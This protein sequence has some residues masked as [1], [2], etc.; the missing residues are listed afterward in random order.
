MIGRPED[1]RRETRIITA[2]GVL[3]RKHCEHCKQSNAIRDCRFPGRDLSSQTVLPNVLVTLERCLAGIF[4]AGIG[5]CQ[6]WLFKEAAPSRDRQDRRNGIQSLPR[7]RRF[8]EEDAIFKV[9]TSSGSPVPQSS[10]RES[11]YSASIRGP[12]R[13]DR[14]RERER[15]RR[16]KKGG[17]S[18]SA[19]FSLHRRRL[20]PGLES[21]VQSKRGRVSRREFSSRRIVVGSAPA[22][23]HDPSAR[24]T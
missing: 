3:S 18:R 15:E 23:F 16:G 11:G 14:R 12:A 4:K 2:R 1:A 7:R 10:C 6:D 13:I 19:T 17:E 8:Q 20:N 22:K 5:R 21:I 24:G 9:S